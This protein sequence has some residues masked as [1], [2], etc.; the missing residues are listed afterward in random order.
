MRLFHRRFGRYTAAFEPEEAALIADLVDQVRQM[1]AA[2]RAEASADPLARMTG[3]VMAP[4]TPP[5]DPAI[6]RLLPD[7]H[8]SDP[9][10]A[11]TMRMLREPDLIALK[12]ASAVRLLDSL[13]R[14]GG[15]V[16]LDASAAQAWSAT[17][18]DVRLAL[19]VRLNITEDDY[20]PP[21]DT[22][23]D[24]ME[25]AIFATYRWLSAVQ[26]SLVNALMD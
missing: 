6:A 22:D 15:T 12:D 2:R 7:F 5:A 19:A 3:M 20:Q 8:A 4:A 18:N 10:F 25:M 11:S 13:P 9:E 21:V 16:H 1:L 26:D 17:L 14:G 24:G 23:P